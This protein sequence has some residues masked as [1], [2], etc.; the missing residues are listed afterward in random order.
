MGARW[1]RMGTATYFRKTLDFRPSPATDFCNKI[2][3]FRT[4]RTRC[5]ISGQSRK[6]LLTAILAFG[7]RKIVCDTLDQ[8]TALAISDQSK[9]FTPQVFLV[10]GGGRDHF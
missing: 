3:T 1:F 7:H 2:D 8:F 5:F 9:D 10:V 4:C 6:C